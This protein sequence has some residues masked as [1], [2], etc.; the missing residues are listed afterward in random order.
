[1]GPGSGAGAT[2]V[3]CEYCFLYFDSVEQRCPL[4][5]EEIPG[6]RSTLVRD[7]WIAPG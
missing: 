4:M 2:K 1:M 3:I 6:K 7:L 5:I